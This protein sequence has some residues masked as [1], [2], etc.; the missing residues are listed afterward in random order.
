MSE[1]KIN[2][3]KEQQEAGSKT[4]AIV[5]G[6]A[7]MILLPWHKCTGISVDMSE[8]GEKGLRLAGWLAGCGNIRSIE[9]QQNRSYNLEPGAQV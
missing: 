1:S 8:R 9:A 6:L 2:N 3:E 4:I 7:P 5:A